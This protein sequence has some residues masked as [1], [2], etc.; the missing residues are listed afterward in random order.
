MKVQEPKL[1]WSGSIE[2]QKEA[3]AAF[4]QLRPRAEKKRP[5][6]KKRKLR[7]PPMKMITGADWQPPPQPTLPDD[8]RTAMFLDLVDCDPSEVLDSFQRYGGMKAPTDRDMLE[9]ASRREMAFGKHKG[10]LLRE[11]PSNYL[12]WAVAVP[13]PTK[14]LRRFC[15]EAQGELFRRDQ[16]PSTSGGET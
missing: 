12:K 1:S 13:D 8:V 11:V 6:Q 3:N 10:V 15:R 2:A 4:S 7:H 5:H 9:A 16:E 14:G